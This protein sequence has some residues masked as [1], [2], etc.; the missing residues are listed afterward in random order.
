MRVQLPFSILECRAPD[1]KAV[2]TIFKVF[3]MTGRGSN[4]QPPDR[5]ADAL[6]TRPSHTVQFT[7]G[8]G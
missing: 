8:I 6:T 4:P 7:S 5:E 1:K 2:G 3:G